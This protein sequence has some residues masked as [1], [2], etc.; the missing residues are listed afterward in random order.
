MDFVGLKE[1]FKKIPWL[2]FCLF[3]L[4]VLNLIL[5][6]YF[7]WQERS[8]EK[9]SLLPSQENSLKIIFL[10][11]GQ[12][13]AILIRTPVL[14]EAPAGKLE[15]RN[16]LIDG[17]PD[18]SIIY[19]LDRYLPFYERKIDLMILTHP[20]PDHL[21]GLVETLKRYRVEKVFYNG[22]EDRDLSYKEFLREIEEKRIEREIVWRGKIFEFGSGKIEILFPF[23]NLSGKSFKNDNEASIVFKLIYGK[24]SILFTGDATKKV[25]EQLI[26]HNLDLKADILKVSHHG[27]KT[28]TS[29]EFLEKVKPKYAIISVGKNNKFGHPSLRVLKNLEKIGAKVLRTDQMG[30]IMFESNGQSLKILNSKFETINK[31]QNLDSNTQIDLGL[32][33]F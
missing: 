26:K 5:L 4:L 24:T 21:N 11:V 9:L 12:G 20:D 22:V 17:G 30:D 33:K 13:D 25:E 7:Y 14:A 28:A 23:E 2:I 27:S 19:K 3:G 15:R 29:L 16:V 1:K 6:G 10:N 32:E 8:G 18:K 31:S